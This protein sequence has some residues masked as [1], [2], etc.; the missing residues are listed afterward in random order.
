MDDLLGT[1]LLVGD[2]DYFKKSIEKSVELYE[3]QDNP[4]ASI[5]GISVFTNK[6]IPKDRALLVDK[7]GK[8]LQIFD[9]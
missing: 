5:F 3:K 8:V 1:K 4:Y 6:Y 2:V 7:D 9:L